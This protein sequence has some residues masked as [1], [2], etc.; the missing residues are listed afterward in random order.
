ML[1]KVN[2][3][4]GLDKCYTILEG[5]FLQLDANPDFQVAL[6]ANDVLANLYTL[7]KTNIQYERQIG[8]ASIGLT[9]GDKKKYGQMHAPLIKQNS[10]LILRGIDTLIQNQSLDKASQELIE[11][12]VDYLEAIE[13]S[14]E[15]TGE[16]I[17]RSLGIVDFSSVRK[18]AGEKAVAIH[19]KLSGA[20]P[21]DVSGVEAKEARID[22][23][24]RSV[25]V[26]FSELK[27]QLETFV[28]A[29]SQA[30]I[31][32]LKCYYDLS[33]HVDVATLLAFQI[34]HNTL[35]LLEKFQANKESKVPNIDNIFQCALG[36]VIYLANSLKIKNQTD[37]SLAE[38]LYTLVDY[39]FYTRFE[40]QSLLKMAMKKKKNLQNAVSAIAT[41]MELYD[42]P[43]IEAIVE[44]VSSAAEKDSGVYL[45]A[46]D[47]LPDVEAA[48][49]SVAENHEAEK[50]FTFYPGLEFS[51]ESNT[52]QS[53]KR[54]RQS[55]YFTAS[56]EFMVVIDSVGGGRVVPG[57]AGRPA[58]V[59]FTPTE[60]FTL[61]KELNKNKEF[62]IKTL[63]VPLF[64]WACLQ[65]EYNIFALL[66]KKVV[67]GILGAG[68]IKPTAETESKVK[69]VAQPVP[70]VSMHQRYSFMFQ[71]V[72]VQPQ[73]GQAATAKDA[74]A[75]DSA[76]HRPS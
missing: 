21:V 46:S 61:A 36:N 72:S 17:A 38:V 66:V 35:H 68:E 13:K 15:I 51:T 50:S 63:L 69:P 14:P 43:Q 39:T 3:M 8:E 28:R 11:A 75:V 54:N 27:L 16:A 34:L 70:V 41:Q 73:A 59:Y 58:S 55:V 71:A 44:E 26:S 24:H 22:F 67:G 1:K 48:S 29:F 31:S 30:A 53:Q 47:Q 76:E 6:K 9:G 60:V 10:Q 74:G 5:K 64:E 65:R 42:K 7:I 45:T 33:R 18:L 19:G 52:A 40:N 56:E 4:P 32:E 62:D 12:Y 20:I 57:G 49:V 25:T 23:G 37:R 2:F